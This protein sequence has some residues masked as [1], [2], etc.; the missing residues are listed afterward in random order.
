MEAES[1]AH[2]PGSP[3][4]VDVSPEYVLSTQLVGTVAGPQLTVTWPMAASPVWPLPLAYWKR[5][6]AALMVTAPLVFQ[7]F[8]R[9]PFFIHTATPAVASSITIR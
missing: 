5:K 6:L 3:V 7:E 4:A 8:P 1:S 9:L 2:V